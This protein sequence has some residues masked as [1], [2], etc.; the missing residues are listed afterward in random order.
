MRQTSANPTPKFRVLSSIIYAFATAAVMIFTAESQASNYTWTGNNSSIWG[1]KQNWSPAN[2]PP[3]SADVALFGSISV[4]STTPTVSDARSINT[5]TFNSGALAYNIGGTNTLT[6]NS[7]GI[8]NNASNT[9]TFSLATIA[10]GANQTWSAASGNLSFTGSSITL[11]SNTLTIAGSL[12]TS[13]SNVI[14]GVGNLLKGGTGSLTLSGANSYGGTTTVSAGTLLAGANA[15]S[16][17]NG[18]FGNTTS[19]I[20]L[21]DAN[22]TSNN[23][24]VSLLTGGAF[25]IGRTV[26]VANQATTGTY[27]IGGNTDNNSSFSGAITINQNLMVSQVASAGSNALSITGGIGSGNNTTKTVTFAGPGNINVGTTGISNST[28][29]LNVSVTSGTTAF[30]VANTYSGSTSVSGGTLKSSAANALGGTSGISVTNTG[31]LVL[32]ANNTIN[33]A[34]TMTLNG[35]VITNNPA[36]KNLVVT[37]S[38]GS[39]TDTS[40]T[41]GLG[42]LTLQ[43]RSTLDFLQS[44]NTIVFGQTAGLAFA[45]S[46]AFK[47]DIFNYI[48]DSTPTGNFDHL[49]FQ[50]DMSTLTGDFEFWNGSSFV[51]AT[52]TQLGSSG[53]WEITPLTPVPEPSTWVAAALSLLV[54]AYSQR[55]RFARAIKRTT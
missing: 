23:S 4:V 55:R 31:S 38:E 7:G 32:T 19:A 26:N 11:A 51:D 47:L 41:A 50:Q 33:D 13:I 3:G 49:V 21:G 16:G 6:I 54:V 15:P 29:T 43:S 37:G 10:L 20:T 27:T 46:G 8:T 5:I 45:D 24:S 44:T 30:N 28:G 18:A 35:N 1:T 2:G 14:S 40:A 36:T 52:A 48:G 53:F 12:N 34:A 9:E 17:A 39:S 42:K 25:T 22:T